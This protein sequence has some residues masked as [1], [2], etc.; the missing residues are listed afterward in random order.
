MIDVDSI[1]SQGLQYLDWATEEGTAV[2]PLS[3][4]LKESNII[5][6]ATRDPIG[7]LGSPMASPKLLLPTSHFRFWRCKTG[8]HLMPTARKKLSFCCKQVH[9]PSQNDSILFNSTRN[10]RHSHPG[11]CHHTRTTAG[12]WYGIVLKTTQ[13]G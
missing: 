3:E 9:H 12:Y 8:L 2:S 13:P 5:Q 4:S 11:S 6:T 10:L 1:V 7:V